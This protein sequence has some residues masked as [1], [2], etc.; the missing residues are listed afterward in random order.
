MHTPRSSAPRQDV[1]AVSE[2]ML[3]M[4]ASFVVTGDPTPPGSSVAASWDPVTPGDQ[5]YLVIGEA[6]C[7]APL[8]Y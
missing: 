7:A 1:V 5:R 8:E 4:W 6:G 3:E 2:A